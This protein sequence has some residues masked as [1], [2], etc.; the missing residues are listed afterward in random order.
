MT[1]KYENKTQYFRHIIK[2]KQGEFEKK[3][4]GSGTDDKSNISQLQ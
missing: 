2:N 3:I 1:T 4:Q